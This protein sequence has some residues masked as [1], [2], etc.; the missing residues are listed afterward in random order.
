MSTATHTHTNENSQALV[1]FDTQLTR[2]CDDPPYLAYDRSMSAC[3]N[4][5]SPVLSRVRATSDVCH[6]VSFVCVCLAMTWRRW[7]YYYYSLSRL[8]KII[9]AL[10]TAVLP[11]PVPIRIQ[12]RFDCHAVGLV[13]LH[14]FEV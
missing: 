3:I 1:E 6:C 12:S 2:A 13:F 7:L 5:L 9:Y 4:D 11:V 10:E 14:L 8:T